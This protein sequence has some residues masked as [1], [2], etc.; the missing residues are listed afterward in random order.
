M[1]RIN[2][3]R[4]GNIISIY[5][6][7]NDYDPEGWGAVLCRDVLDSAPWAKVVARGE[8]R[9]EDAEAMENLIDFIKYFNAADMTEAELVAAIDDWTILIPWL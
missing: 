8:Y 6:A 9:I 4:N 7:D 1:D 5:C 2:Y 3:K